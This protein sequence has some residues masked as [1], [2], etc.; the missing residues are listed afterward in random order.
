MVVIEILEGF[1]IF[2]Q[3]IDVWQPPAS[4]RSPLF[5]ILHMYWFICFCIF[6]YMFLCFCVFLCIW[7]FH[8]PPASTSSPP[9]P[10]IGLNLHPKLIIG[11][12][13]SYGLKC[14][15]NEAIENLPSSLLC[16]IF[17]KYYPMKFMKLFTHKVSRLC[18]YKWIQD[19]LN[20]V[21][22]SSFQHDILP[23]CQLAHVGACFVS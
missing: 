5:S 7:V 11:S 3:T 8:Q 2:P 13:G 12:Q 1:N 16:I 9:F 18:R 15:L 21:V 6:V 17:T 20:L 10:I 4:T 14:G 23:S 22:L 19:Q